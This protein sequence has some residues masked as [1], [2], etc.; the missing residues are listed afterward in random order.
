[1]FFPDGAN[2]KQKG[3][4]TLE[5]TFSK[6]NYPALGVNLECFENPK[7]NS[8]DQIKS[9]LSDNLKVKNKVIRKDELFKLNYEIK[10][11]DEKLVIWKVLHYL[12]PR[13]FRLL[14]FSEACGFLEVTTVIPRFWRPRFWRPQFWRP[15][16][17]GDFI[18]LVSSWAHLLHTY[19]LDFGDFDFGDLNFDRSQ[20]SPKSR[21]DCTI[22]KVSLPYVLSEIF[23]K[24]LYYKYRTS[25]KS[26][27]L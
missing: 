9:F 17:I 2:I 19:N 4:G 12:K 23:S 25:G 13:S 14:R 7:L 11:D 15:S 10:V 26:E 21:D 27:V 18:Y 20:K 8:S 5:V 3:L 22:V 24:C 16:Q 6:Q 1:M